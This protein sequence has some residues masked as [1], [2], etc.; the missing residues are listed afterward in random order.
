V[1]IEIEGHTDDI[2]DPA[3]NE[4]IGLERAESVQ[5]YLYEQYQIP[6]HKISI[7]SYGE[8]KPAVQGKTRDARAQNR[9]VVIKVLA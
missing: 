2:G 4:R 5:R 3:T 8:E 7:I 9:R 6:L 1:F